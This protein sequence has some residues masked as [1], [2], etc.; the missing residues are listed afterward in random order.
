MKFKEFHLKDAITFNLKM[1]IT[2]IKTNNL[3]LDGNKIEFII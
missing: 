3:L 1:I 2:K